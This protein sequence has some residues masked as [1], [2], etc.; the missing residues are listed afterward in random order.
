VGEKTVLKRKWGREGE[1]RLKR[2]KARK[3]EDI[4]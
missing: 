3:K 1:G 4:V 2:T